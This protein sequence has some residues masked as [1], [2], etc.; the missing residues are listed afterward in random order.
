M[1]RRLRVTGSCWLLFASLACCHV[2]FAQDLSTGLLQS[3]SASHTVRGTVVNSV[4]G[5]P[6]YRALVQIGGQY[7]ML[8]DH[9]GH[10]EF[11]GVTLQGIPPWAMKPGYFSQD[12]F[13]RF[14]PLDTSNPSEPDSELIVKLVPEAI[15]SGTVTGQ[16][17][18][19]LEG[20]PVQLKTLAVQDGLSRWRPRQ[21]TRTNSEGQYRFAELEAGKY[22]I[23]T[24]F[25]TEGLADSESSLAYIPARYP[26]PGG[27]SSSSETALVLN[28]G[29]HVVA[30][31]NPDVEKLFPVTGT[32]N[33][34]GE[35][36]GV[37]FRVETASGEEF[38]PT[39]RFTPRSGEFRVM[40]PG[41][42]YQVTATAYLRQGPV[43]A[44]REITVPQAPVGGISFVMQQYATIPVDVGMDTIDQP[45]DSIG[46]AGAPAP[47][48]NFAENITLASASGEGFTPYLSA[49]PLH[50][51][52]DD[53]VSEEQ[54]P[55]AIENVSPGRYVLR[56]QPPSPWYIASASCGGVDLIHDELAVGQGSVGCSIRVVLRNDSGS[57]RA[58]VRNP[59]QNGASSGQRA[60]YVYA[61]PEGNLVQPV[62]M[63]NQQNGEYSADGMAPG[64]Y[65][66]LALDHH[67]ELPY[68]EPDAMR[69]YAGLGQE[70]TVPANGKA[71]IEVSLATVTP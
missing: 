5:E 67:E 35:S 4:T 14:R 10:F 43:E 47:L 31:L 22:E 1:N 61:V 3:S 58:T 59:D 19:P 51:S 65:L 37:A 55:L 66:V 20:I 64:R 34:Y 53:S 27:G 30:D 11:N 46:Q 60:L 45:S 7:A 21:Q 42:A 56:A 69:R 50:H 49:R 33:G 15:I 44:R 6:I 25:H 2:A 41:G 40:L 48:T 12:R 8:T 32:I 28:P 9:E 24:G 36:R 63:L 26:P 62:V 57:A 13:N 54:G 68:R 70:I 29:D 39:A 71:D 38:T 17:G 18:N 23:T 52:G 16:D